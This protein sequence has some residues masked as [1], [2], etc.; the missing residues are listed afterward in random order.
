MYK[1]PGRCGGFADGT[2]SADVAMLQGIKYW[3]WSPLAVREAA[4]KA[5]ASPAGVARAT[6][7]ELVFRHGAS[8][9]AADPPRP[10]SAFLPHAQQAGATRPGADDSSE[11]H[12]S[13]PRQLL[14]HIMRRPSLDF[15][16]WA[17]PSCK[18]LRDSGTV[19]TYSGEFPDTSLQRETVETMIM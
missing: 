15:K 12:A 9:S 16:V 13:L 14:R 7:S 10:P 18:H 2:C 3:I 19:S 4:A 5:V 17:L 6:S 11:E 8:L 1:S